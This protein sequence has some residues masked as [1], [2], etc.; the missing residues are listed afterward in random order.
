M[1]AEGLSPESGVNFEEN[2]RNR[3]KSKVWTT[4]LCSSRSFFSRVTSSV[5]WFQLVNAM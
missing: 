4:T 5:E 3:P 1:S 2:W